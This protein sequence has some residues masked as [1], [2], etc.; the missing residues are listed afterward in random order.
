MLRTFH[1]SVLSRHY[2]QLPVTGDWTPT[3]ANI[4]VEVQ[5]D[6]YGGTSW[7][8]YVA[9]SSINPSD[10][11]RSYSRSGYI[12]PLP[13]RSNL[14]ILPSAT[15]TRIVFDTSK[16]NNLTATGVEFAS[17]KDAPRRTINVRKEVILAGGA[18][19]SPHVLLHSGVGPADVLQA[20]G[21][22]VKLDL[23]GVGQH[24]QDHIVRA[25]VRLSY[26]PNLLH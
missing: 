14:A 1:V 3:L 19:G 22:D 8:A 9:S 6:A 23:P 4:G 25:L 5:D 21:V 7:G 18:V 10:W 2:S 17:S 12:D 20:A 15:V 16:A 26:L 13:P 24:L 11:T